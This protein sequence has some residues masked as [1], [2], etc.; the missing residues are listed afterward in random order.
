MDNQDEVKRVY[1]QILNEKIYEI[2]NEKGKFKS[3]SISYD[4][5]I[6]ISKKN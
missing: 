6:K 1:N 3:K 2:F 5:F 4:N